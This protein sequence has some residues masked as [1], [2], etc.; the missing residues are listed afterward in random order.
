M[1]TLLRNP[2]L[3]KSRKGYAPP[4]NNAADIATEIASSTPEE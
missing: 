1:Y 3:I 2:E 4:T